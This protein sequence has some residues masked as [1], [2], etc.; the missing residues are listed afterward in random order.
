MKAKHLCLLAAAVCLCVGCGREYDTARFREKTELLRQEALADWV[1][2]ELGDA[3]AGDA[4]HAVFFSVSDGTKTASVY[5]GTGASVDEAWENSVSNAEEA[6]KKSGTEPEWVKTDVVYIAGKISAEEL[7]ESLLYSEVGFLSYGAAFDPEFQTALLEQELNAAFVYDYENGG[8]DLDALNTYLKK[9]K[10]ESVKDLPDDYILFRCAGWICDEKDAVYRLNASG[11]GYGQRI[12]EPVDDTAAA[13]LVSGAAEY[14]MRNISQKG[15]ISGANTMQQAEVLH[16]LLCA[17]QLSPNA[18]LKEK[19]SLVA[20]Y[21]AEKVSYDSDGNVFFPDEDG[22]TAAVYALTAAA[23]AEYMDVF[24][25]PE[26]LELC[27]NIGSRLLSAQEQETD[28]DRSMAVYALCRLYDITGETAWLDGAVR[29]A[30]GIEVQDYLQRQ[31][32]WTS[33]AMNELTKYVPDRAEYYV[34][35]LENAQKNL[36]TVSDMEITSPAGLGMLTAAFETYVRMTEYGGSADGFYLPVLLEGIDVRAERQ[37]NGCFFPEIAM[38]MANPPDVLGAFMEREN[39]FGVS[40]ETIC[41][42][43]ES[44]YLYCRNYAAIGQSRE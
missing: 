22:N 42:N 25:S 29:A 35:A 38:Y 32:F 11:L 6:L 14:L 39:K 30:E 15:E 12:M 34:L 36:K 41:Q 23:L 1:R 27:S 20:K 28:A 40:L 7:K 24:E 3:P 5:Y 9:S 43:I 4:G 26:Y 21:L 33:F 44:Y 37:L 18:E 2:Q 19:I 8:I 13:G 17:C 31:D 16:A 10:R